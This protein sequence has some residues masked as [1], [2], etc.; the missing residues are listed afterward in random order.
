MGYYELLT[1]TMGYQERSGR[2]PKFDLLRQKH[3]GGQ[4]VRSSKQTRSSKHETSYP[5]MG[6]LGEKIGYHRLPGVT[7]GYRRLPVTL[8]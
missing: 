4:E 3:Y 1:V 2:S 7:T 6:I 8:T 5:R